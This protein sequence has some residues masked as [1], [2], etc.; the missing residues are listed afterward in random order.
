MRGSVVSMTQNV[1]IWY[2]RDVIDSPQEAGQ[3]GIAGVGDQDGSPGAVEDEE[4]SASYG[5]RASLDRFLDVVQR[6]NAADSDQR[7]GRCGGGF[8][9]QARVHPCHAS[10]AVDGVEHDLTGPRVDRPAQVAD[11]V[12]AAV[13]VAPW[14]EER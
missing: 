9:D 3:D 7:N 1:Q 12:G 4:R 8:R 11:P 13:E 5:V 10:V 6:A 2:S 14:A